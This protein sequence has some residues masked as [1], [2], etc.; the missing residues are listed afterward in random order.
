MRD[1]K[2][3]SDRKRSKKFV[4]KRVQG[5]LLKHAVRYWI[6]SLVAVGSLTTIGWLMF[7]P[8]GSFVNVRQH[9]AHTLPVLLIAL[10]ISLVFLPMVLYDLVC[11]SH[12]F[13]GPMFRLKRCM[14]EVAAGQSV[15]P[16]KFRDGDFWQEYAD[17]F[18]AVMVRI[19]QLS[20]DAAAGTNGGKPAA[21]GAT[22]GPTI[23][24]G[25]L[26][27]DKPQDVVAVVT[28]DLPPTA[29][30]TTTDA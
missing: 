7:T 8:D 27:A 25:T 21:E 17:A 22:A 28:T 2:K 29:P 5:A 26:E 15:A 9:L 24:E 6:I 19:E 11:L 12:K 4:D 23:V 3:N 10:A 1:R 13:V 20:Q 18:N 30:S 16:I 14:L